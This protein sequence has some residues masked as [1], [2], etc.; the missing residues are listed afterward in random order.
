LTAAHQS[1]KQTLTASNGICN[2]NF[3]QLNWHFA[4]SA[5]VR[6][7]PAIPL[8]EEIFGSFKIKKILL[9]YKFNI[10]ET[11]DCKVTI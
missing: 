10:F 3:F 5:W 7:V 11:E 1:L 9:S 6:T 8:E 4:I 2:D